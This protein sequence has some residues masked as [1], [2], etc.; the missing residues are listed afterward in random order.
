MNLLKLTRENNRI[1]QLNAGNGLKWESEW[2][3]CIQ[4]SPWKNN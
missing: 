2:M 4:A 3:V 1:G